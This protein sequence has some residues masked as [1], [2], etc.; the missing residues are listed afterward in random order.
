MTG[1]EQRLQYLVKH[2]SAGLIV[3]L[4]LF[5][6]NH[7]ALVIEHAL[8][9]RAE[10]MAH[11]VALHEQHPLERALGGG[12]EI[13][14]A[15]EIGRAIIVGGADLLEI[16]EEVL[17]QILRPVEH[18]MFEQMGKTGLALGL[19]LRSDIVPHGDPDHRRLMIFVD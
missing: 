3:A 5:I 1:R 11:P 15:V 18:Q 9:D 2:Q 13:I 19:V 6:L 7:P 14:G 12:L 16:F 4:P 17:G 10:Q 8:A